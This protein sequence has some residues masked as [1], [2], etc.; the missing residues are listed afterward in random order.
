MSKSKGQ[1]LPQIAAGLGHANVGWYSVVLHGLTTGGE[2]T[3]GNNLCD[4]PC[5]HPLTEHGDKDASTKTSV[6]WEWFHQRPDANIGIVLEPS[7]LV[8]IAPDS[9]DWLGRFQQRGLPRTATF[10]SGGGEG[11]QHHLYRRPDGCPAYRLCRSGEY[12]I[13]SAG[14]CVVPPS[15]HKSGR[16]YEWIIPPDEFPQGL[17]PAPDWAVA[18]LQQAA[19]KAPKANPGTGVGDG[20]PVRLSTVGLA[21]WHGERVKEKP[22]GITDRSATLFGIGGFLAEAGASERTI[23]DAI[24]NRDV[25]LGFSKYTDRR[26]RSEYQRI[27]AKAL[28]PPVGCHVLSGFHAWNLTSAL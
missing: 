1:Q 3:C 18:M 7:N 13:M 11:H 27:A 22:D 4:T 8:D 16:Q 9:L 14:Y 26:D 20:P 17:P 25:A 5:K 2:C 28:Q 23:V 15:R 24:E 12:D 19:D 6:I 10:R 21:Y